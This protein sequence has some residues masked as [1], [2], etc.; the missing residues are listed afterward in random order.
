MSFAEDTDKCT[1]EIT[2]NLEENSTA[3]KEETSVQV[4]ETEAAHPEVSKQQRVSKSASDNAAVCTQA[5][6]V[7]Q[8]VTMHPGDTETTRD[9][10]QQVCAGA[11]HNKN[12]IKQEEE[13]EAYEIETMQQDHEV[14]AEATDHERV[15]PQGVASI[16]QE[17]N[18]ELYTGVLVLDATKEELY[19]ASPESEV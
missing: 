3:A 15:T 7:K 8:E 14:R 6:D 18:K 1:E 11:L 10:E 5:R 13:Q 4:R 2:S 9:V 12:G 19:C 17:S 16:F